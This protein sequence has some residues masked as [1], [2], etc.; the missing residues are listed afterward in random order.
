MAFNHKFD[1]RWYDDRLLQNADIK[2][3]FRY[4]YINHFHEKQ[5]QSSVTYDNKH[6][7]DMN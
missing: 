7:L 2:S 1:D 5:K 3:S 4:M 6:S